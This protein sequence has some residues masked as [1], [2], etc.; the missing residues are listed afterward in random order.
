MEVQ[1]LMRRRA[2]TLLLTSIAVAMLTSAA[3]A[4]DARERRL[5]IVPDADPSV[6]A[7]AAALE[8]TDLLVARTAARVLPS[9]GV[10]AL[11]ATGQAL[12]HDDMLVRRN[13]AMGLAGLGVRGLELVERAMRDAEPMVRQGAIFSLIGF[14]PSTEVSELLEQ[15]GTDDSQLVKSAVMLVA[16][17]SYRTAE[18]IP[19]PAQGWRFA[20]DPDDVGRE[21][22][23][24]AEGF[25]D[26]GWA[27]IAIEQ[28]W[29]EAGHDYVG[30]AWYRRVIELPDRDTPPRVML[31]FQG[32]DESAWVWVNGQFAGEHDIGP[33]GWD[34]PFRLDVTDMLR[35]GGQNQIT[36]RAMNTAHAGGIWRPITVVVLEPAA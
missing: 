33:T 26:S 10:E 5:A 30:V 7:L 2:V 20:L 34:R 1:G 36:V 8:D 25:D 21:Q 3:L 11:V 31:E 4:D 35:W 9:K 15:A 18:T 6:Q 19:L 27:E 17:A 12:R 14:P 22:E 23:W 13:A 29:Q 24:F 28:T 16:R 32:V